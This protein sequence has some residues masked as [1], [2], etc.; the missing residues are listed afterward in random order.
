MPGGVRAAGHRRDRERSRAS[1]P[2][3]VPGLGAGPQ[4][5]PQRG[6]VTG[7]SSGAT[8][9]YDY[10]TVAYNA[11]TGAR[12][13]ARRF[14]G[15]VSK[16][17]EA[18]AIAAAPGGS[19]VYVTGFSHERIGHTEYVTIAYNAATGARAW[20]SRFVASLFFDFGTGV[21]AAP[22]GNA[23]YVT[24]YNG[25]SC[26]DGSGPQ[27]DHSTLRYN[28]ATGTQEWAAPGAEHCP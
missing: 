8:T 18:L 20:L 25:F 21:A 16:D 19:R 22:N 23:V 6:R 3:P 5:V 17:D 24:G 10:A 4:G 7:F 28:T 27:I 15:P 14:N 11:A 2:N 13:W 9:H 12:R 1:R 26:P